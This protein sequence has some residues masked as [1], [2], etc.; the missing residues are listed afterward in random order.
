MADL[1]KI[2]TPLV[3]RNPTQAVRPNPNPTVPFD[4]SDVTRVSKPVDPQELFQQNTGLSPNS[5]DA[6]KILTDLLKDPTVTVSMIRSISMLQ[7]VLQLIPSQNSALSQEIQQLFGALLMQPEDIIAELLRQE[8]NTTMF[9]GDFF[10][11]LRDIL[12]QSAGKPELATGIGVLLK[13]LNATLSRHDVLQSISNN[14]SFLAQSLHVS[15]HLSGKLESLMLAFRAPDASDNFAQLKSQVSEVLSEIQN[16]VLFSPALEKISSLV[17]Y[18]MSRYNTNEDFLPQAL[19]L[20]LSQMDGDAQKLDLVDKLQAFLNQYLD[21]AR[22]VRGAEE[23]SRVIDVLSKIIGEQANSKD[24]ELLSGDKVDR[25]IHSLLASPSNFTPL[26][27]FILPVEY[28]DLRAFAEIWIDPNAENSGGGSEDSDT[29]MLLTFD[30]EGI[31]RFESDIYVHGK[32]LSLNLF[33]PPAYLSAF[34]GIA[35]ALRQTVSN[36]GYSF[37]SINIDKLESTRSLMDVFTNLPH[38]RTGIDVKI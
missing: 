3:E 20:L 33:C 14:L 18:N 19:N 37:E 31:G 32:R 16:S 5:S 26:L 22:N 7:E 27:H 8:Q 34:K 9:K 10:D 13:G 15:P 4:L 11:T 28:M 12:A 29:H 24:V 25:I 2:S 21:D 30:V 17:V 6:P 38:K 35:P 36:L 23:E 1:L